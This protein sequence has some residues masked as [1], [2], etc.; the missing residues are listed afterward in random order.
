MNGEPGVDKPRISFNLNTIVTLTSLM[1]VVGGLI[2]T[3]AQTNARFQL[4][5]EV[6]Q[7]RDKKQQEWNSTLDADRKAARALYEQNSREQLAVITKLGMANDTVGAEIGRLQKSDETTDERINRLADVYT[8]RIDEVRENIGEL[9]TGQALTNQR[10]EEIKNLIMDGF[11]KQKQGALK[12]GVVPEEY[13]A[14]R[15]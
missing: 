8:K 1:I 2:Y 6:L 15:R 7:D 3:Q 12:P 9:K 14:A 4:V 13:K 5:S 10:Q 11:G